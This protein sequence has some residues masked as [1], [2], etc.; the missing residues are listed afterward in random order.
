MDSYDPV[1]NRIGRNLDSVLTT[2]TYDDLYRLTHQD[3]PGQ[4]CTYVLDPVGNLEVMWEASAH[5]KTFT[6]DAADRLV[7][8]ALGANLTT[9]T[10]SDFGALA[11]EIT[12]SAVT[13]Y[14]YDGQDQLIGV[15]QHSG[16]LSTYTFG[17]DGM[18]RTAQEGNVQ[19][20]TMVWDG[21]DYLFLDGPSSDSLVMTLDGEIVAC[22]SKDLLTDPLGTLVAEIAAGASLSGAFNM[23]PYGSPVV[24]AFSTPTIPFRFIAAYGYYFDTSDRDYVRARELEKRLG[25]WMQTDPIWP[26]QR[27]VSYVGG[28]PIVQVDPSGLRP[29]TKDRSIARCVYAFPQCDSMCEAEYLRDLLDCRWKVVQGILCLWKAYA[30]LLGCK[31]CCTQHHYMHDEYNNDAVCECLNPEDREEATE[32]LGWPAPP[33]GMCPDVYVL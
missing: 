15:L 1:G 20:T 13:T 12:G 2:W 17:G 22:G 28:R 23:Y 26:F 29:A 24:P 19:P 25:R 27:A 5:P 21:S 10:F 9:F 31:A 33:P 7:T 6:F 14:T 3:K 32:W 30:D 11:S 16:V 4:V 18:R 8:M